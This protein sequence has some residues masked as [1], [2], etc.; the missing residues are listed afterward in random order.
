MSSHSLSDHFGQ[1]L[2]FDSF[3]SLELPSDTAKLSGLKDAKA[4]GLFGQ[5]KLVKPFTFA[6]TPYEYKVMPLRECPT[7]ES[8]QQADTPQQAVEY[9]RL[10]IPS[11][12]YYDP[13]REC[14]VVLLL[15]NRTRIKGHQFLSIGTLDSVMVHPRDV[16]RLAVITNAAKIILAHNHPSGE[17]QPSGADVTI[18][19]D[20][21]RAGQLMKI[22]LLDH[23]IIGAQTH[24]SLRETGYFFS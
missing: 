12:P 14:C 1:Q 4:S 6:A 23:I 18:T 9:W 24:C 7:P 15:N 13:E 21:I 2:L 3:Q 16:F 22:E 20:L 10:H 8:L 17:P 11:N 19:R 5:R